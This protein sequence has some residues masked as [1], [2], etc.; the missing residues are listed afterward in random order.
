MTFPSPKP[1][2]SLDRV[3]SRGIEPESATVL[4]GHPWDYLSDHYPLFVEFNVEDLE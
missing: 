2:L 4:T 1:L 3:Y